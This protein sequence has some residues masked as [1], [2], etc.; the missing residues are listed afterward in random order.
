MLRFILLGIV[1]FSGFYIY[2]IFPIHHGPGEV[3]PNRPKIER[4]TWEKPFSFKNSTVIP[5]R[6][7][8]GEVRVLERERYFLDNKVSYSPVDVLVGWKALS[9]E[10]NLD[11]IHF[12]LDN[13]LFEYEFSKPPLPVNEIISQ[14][15]LWHLVPSSESIEVQVKK[16]RKG[17]IISFTG[18][19]VDIESETDYGW[20]SE[21]ENPK[22]QSFKNTIIWIT[23]L[24]VK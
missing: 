3:T 11:H 4:V 15:D 21:L 13:R 20:K 14:I 17:N 23:D 5:L 6:K 1:A 2:T 10:R 9:D 22:N 12:S 24:Q 8:S 19:I 7:I 16:L 18:F